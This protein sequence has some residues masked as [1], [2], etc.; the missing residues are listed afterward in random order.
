MPVGGQ[1]GRKEGNMETKTL[2][3]DEH[4]EIIAHYVKGVFR[5][6]RTY[7]SN[8]DGFLEREITVYPDG[9]Y[10]VVCQ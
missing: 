4:T 7:I 5:Y 10:K 2:Y 3:K 9:T 6:T 8:D 1:T